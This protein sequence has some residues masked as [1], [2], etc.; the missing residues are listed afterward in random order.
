M[1]PVQLTFLLSSSTVFIF[2]IQIAST[3]PSKSTHFRSGVGLEAA[4]L[5]DVGNGMYC[6]CG[7]LVMGFADPTDKK[8]RCVVLNAQRQDTAPSRNRQVDAPVHRQVSN[9]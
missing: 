5:R 6:F 8:S 2:S 3:G 7:G 1:P 9:A 4:N